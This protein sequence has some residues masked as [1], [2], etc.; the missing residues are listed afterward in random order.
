MKLIDMFEFTIIGSSGCWPK[1]T[2]CDTQN[3]KMN[4]IDTP[5]FKTYL[6]TYELPE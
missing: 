4:L 2:S 3:L 5:F 6:P 1:S